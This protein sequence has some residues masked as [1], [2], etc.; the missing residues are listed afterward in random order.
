MRPAN[1]NNFKVQENAI[2]GTFKYLKVNT[3]IKQR[4]FDRARIEIKLYLTC[5]YVK[6]CKNIINY[7]ILLTLIIKFIFFRNIVKCS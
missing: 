1:P 7:F 2:I 4:N 6:C 5:Q 3:E